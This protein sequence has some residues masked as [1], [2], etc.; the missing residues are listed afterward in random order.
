MAALVVYDSAYGNTA[1]IADAIRS[2]LGDGARAHVINDVDP[3]RLATTDLL[4][5]GSPTQAGRATAAMQAWLGSLPAEHARGMSFAAFDTRM[6]AQH[7]GLGLRLVMGLIGYAAPRIAAS[8]SAKGAV[9][10][11]DPKG[12]LVTGREG[13]LATG[14]LQNARAWASSLLRTN[15]RVAA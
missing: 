13:P 5:V 2:A 7:Q 4:I 6:D 1:R 14:E 8:L 11:A 12:F 10:I 15:T 9:A 3:A